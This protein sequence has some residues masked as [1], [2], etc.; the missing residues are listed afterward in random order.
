MFG[1]FVIIAA[2]ALTIFY[3]TIDKIGKRSDVDKVIDFLEDLVEMDAL[4]IEIGSNCGQKALAKSDSVKTK[5]KKKKDKKR[6]K[7][8]SEI[9]QLINKI[10]KKL[11]K[12]YTFANIS[13]NHYEKIYKEEILNLYKTSKLKGEAEDSIKE[14]LESLLGDLR[15]PGESFANKLETKASIDTLDAML[16]MDGIKESELQIVARESLTKSTSKRISDMLGD[17]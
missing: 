3:F 12:G 13:R 16:T 11:E 7:N 5:N 8:D 4:R 14:V 6:K 15:K 2:M 1:F 17:E 10:D 9:L